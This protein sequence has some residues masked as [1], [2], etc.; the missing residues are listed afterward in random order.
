M[1]LIDQE[2]TIKKMKDDV[3]YNS[4]LFELLS[5]D[6]SSLNVKIKN[7]Q[8]VNQTRNQL[9]SE[10]REASSN[11]MMVMKLEMEAMKADKV[12]KDN[13]LNMLYVVIESH[14]KIDVHA[15]FNEIEVKRVEERRIQRERELAQEATQH[16]KAVVVDAEAGGSSSVVDVEMTEAEADPLGFVL[17]GEPSESL[18][19]TDI[20]H[21]VHALQKKKKAR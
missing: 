17:A 1:V 19:L 15:V 12:M 8:D 2:E 14:L 20:L 16:R 4:Q 13:Q 7:L 18:D 11:E 10:M 5:L 9:L 6:I 21:R 3:H